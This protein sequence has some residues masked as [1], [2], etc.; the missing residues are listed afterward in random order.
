MAPSLQ[1][2]GTFTLYNKHY[3]FLCAIESNFSYL[4]N[5]GEG[6]QRTANDIR[7]VLYYNAIFRKYLMFQLNF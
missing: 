5:C 6:T 4:F 1:L 7:L 3:T 2:R